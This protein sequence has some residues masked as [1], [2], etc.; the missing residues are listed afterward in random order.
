MLLLFSPLP[1]WTVFFSPTTTLSTHYITIPR[2]LLPNSATRTDILL[3]HG[4]VRIDVYLHPPKFANS[5]V[6]SVTLLLKSFFTFSFVP[7]RTRLHP[8]ASKSCKTLLVLATSVNLGP[9]GHA[10]SYSQYVVTRVSTF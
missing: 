5:T 6:V 9:H 7:A 2:G 3:R 10:D 1:T 8:V 4:L